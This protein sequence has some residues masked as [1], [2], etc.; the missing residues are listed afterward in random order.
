MRLTRAVAPVLLVGAAAI[1]AGC[2][3]GSGRDSSTETGAPPRGG[4]SPREAQGPPALVN[5]TTEALEA[6]RWTSPAPPAPGS[7]EAAMLEKC[8]RAIRGYPD[9]LRAG[10]ELVLAAEI[11]PRT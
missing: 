6:C 11:T 7:V 2:D 1:A 5:A 3:G 4:R 8:L 10:L 9:P